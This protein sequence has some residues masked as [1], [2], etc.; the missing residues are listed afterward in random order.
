MGNNNK[1]ERKNTIMVKKTMNKAMPSYMPQVPV[2]LST[3][4][5]RMDINP[6]EGTSP[7]INE[8][9]VDGTATWYRPC[10]DMRPTPSPDKNRHVHGWDDNMEISKGGVVGHA[11]KKP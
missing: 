1:T 10:D 2:D 8:K 4:V 7:R 3:N 5:T 6:S 9:E 11:D